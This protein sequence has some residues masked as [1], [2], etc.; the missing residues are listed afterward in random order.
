MAVC[1]YCGFRV[2]EIQRFELPLYCTCCGSS[3]ITNEPEPETLTQDEITKGWYEP[4]GWS[5]E[6]QEFE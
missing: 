5:S 3:E 1:P 2:P 4:L 6:R